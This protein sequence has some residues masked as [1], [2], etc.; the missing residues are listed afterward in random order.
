[1][2]MRRTIWKRAGLGPARALWIWLLGLLLR[3]LRLTWRVRVEGRPPAEGGLLAF[4]H[5]DQVALT[6]APQSPLPAVLVSRSR[7]GEIGARAARGLGFPVL[8]GSTSR[9]AVAAGLG[10]VRSLRAGR[11]VALAVDGPQG[12]RHRIHR[13]PARLASLGGAALIP[14]A[15]SARRGKILRS[16]DRM[17]IPAPFTSV[18]IIWGDPVPPAAIQGG[19]DRVWDRAREMARG[20]G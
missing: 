19:L 10:V 12:P 15:A 4:W 3:L 17:L 20:Q 8:R 16:W 18:F 11:S 2:Y 7:D 9:G 14:V 5:G 13:A 6:A 1:M